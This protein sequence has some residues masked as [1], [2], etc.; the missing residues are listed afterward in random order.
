MTIPVPVLV[1]EMDRPVVRSMHMTGSADGACPEEC[2]QQ[3][4][5]N[6]RLEKARGTGATHVAADYKRINQPEP[7][8]N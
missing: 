8:M 3:Q 5:P 4:R 6:G 2:E 7:S 1:V